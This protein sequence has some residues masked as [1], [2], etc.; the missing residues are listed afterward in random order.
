MIKMNFHLISV[1][2]NAEYNRKKPDL[3]AKSGF[4]L[5]L[6]QSVITILP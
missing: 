2:F 5:W 1:S 3:I 6:N 4:F